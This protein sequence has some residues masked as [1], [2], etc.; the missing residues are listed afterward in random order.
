MLTVAL[1]DVFARLPDLRCRS[2][3]CQDQAEFYVHLAEYTPRELGL[4]RGKQFNQARKHPEWDGR[5]C[6]AHLLRV[7]ELQLDEVGFHRPLRIERV[8]RVA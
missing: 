5:F 3:D 1:S 6:R 2:N 7:L 8:S 4:D